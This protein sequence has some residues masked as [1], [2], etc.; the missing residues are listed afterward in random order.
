MYNSNC[1]NRAAILIIGT[2]TARDPTTVD[3]RTEA[4]VLV[5]RDFRGVISFIDDIDVAAPIE[6]SDGVVQ[7]R[8]L[9]ALSPRVITDFG[10]SGAPVVDHNGD[11]IGF[12][13]GP[14]SASRPPIRCQFC[15]KLA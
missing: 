8:G 4:R 13:V 11:L 3:L 12:V 1:V 7:M 14:S 15:G 5:A 9:T 10:D 6:F 2:S